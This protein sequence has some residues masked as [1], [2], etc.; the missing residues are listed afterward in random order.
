MLPSAPPGNPQNFLCVCPQCSR[1]HTASAPLPC[2]TQQKCSRA[3]PR[4]AVPDTC[5]PFAVT[6]PSTLPSHTWVPLL[7]CSPQETHP[8]PSG[9]HLPR[10]PCAFSAGAALYPGGRPESRECT[11][12][13]LCRPPFLASLWSLVASHNPCRR[14][15][16]HG[17][18]ER[19][20]Q[21]GLGLAPAALHVP[22]GHVGV[23]VGTPGAVSDVAMC[24]PRVLRP[25]PVHVSTVAGLDRVWTSWC[26]F[27]NTG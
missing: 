3:A 20:A 8:C 12:S 2:W 6:E 27:A 5:P 13:L 22:S 4:G 26:A 9:P 24:S 11:L 15:H 16:V 1:P 10:L 7:V 14:D 18:R 25:D 19:T 23:R 17:A 21:E